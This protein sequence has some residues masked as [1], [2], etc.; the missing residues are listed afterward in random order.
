MARRQRPALHGQAGREGRAVVEAAASAAGGGGRPGPRGQ[1]AQRQPSHSEPT[2]QQQQPLSTTQP[3]LTSS[4]AIC[5]AASLSRADAS[6]NWRLR[7]LQEQEDTGRQ[8][9]RMSWLWQ[10]RAGRALCVPPP[11][12]LQRCR[13]HSMTSPMTP[14]HA[15]THLKGTSRCWHV[16]RLTASTSSFMRWSRT[17]RPT[18]T[19]PWGVS[20]TTGKPLCRVRRSR[21][22]RGGGGG[23]MGGWMGGEG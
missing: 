4:T 5:C 15:H 19:P 1:T 6:T 7:S 3:T 9:G 23:W 2:Q 20:R 16:P 12:Q 8:Q 11:G 13:Q 18:H 14:S 10:G 22:L 21:S 17:T